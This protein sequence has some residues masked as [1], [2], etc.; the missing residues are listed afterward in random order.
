MRRLLVAALVALPLRAAA[1]AP[2][3]F[4]YLY[5]EANE[6]S[7]SGGHVAARFA[8][9][10][11]HFQNVGG[12]RIRLFRTPFEQFDHQYRVAGNRPIHVQRV[13]LGA[14][15]FERQRD[16]FEEYY[17]RQQVDF[18]ALQALQRDRDLLQSFA[19]GSAHIPRLPGSAY[20]FADGS[21]PGR[22]DAGDA[23]P[24]SAAITA[25]A[26]QLR[27]RYGGE[28]LDHRAAELRAA[29]A[30]LRPAAAAPSHS[31][32]ALQPAPSSVFADRYRDLLSGLLAVE[33]LRGGLPLRATALENAD[34]EG[35][36]LAAGELAALRRA[37]QQLANDL[38][39]LFASRRPDWG[40]PMLIGMARLDAIATSLRSRHLVVLDVFR[41]DAPLV[42][43][44]QI[45][46]HRARLTAL[47]EERRD[48][49]QAARAVFF[50]D[51]RYDESRLS[52]LELAANLLSELRAATR[53]A[54]DL[55]AHVNSLLPEKSARE[56]TLPLPE[57]DA[58]TLRPA[59]AA[60]RDR[61]A[62]YAAALTGRYP[63]HVVTRNCVTELF[64]LLLAAAP[65][66]TRDRS[67]AA[68]PFIPFLSTARLRAL[69]GP[70]AEQRL[71]SYRESALARMYA[72]E[73]DALVYLRESNVLT[74]SLYERDSRDSP[75]LFFT[76][77]AVLPRPVFGVV[78]LATGL[79]TT[80]A[81]LATLPFDGGATV[82]AGA[83]G[84]L[85]S[86]PELSF[87]NIRKG[88]FNFVP[89]RWL[90][91]GEIPSLFSP[92]QEDEREPAAMPS[93]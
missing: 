47:L 1:A 74:S 24:R 6:G 44:D 88:T 70:A 33:V 78:N 71:P 72:A 27:R 62:A 28:V 4:E 93:R 59:L 75:F 30:A 19:G 86:L 61:E 35:T 22:A 15:D 32:A 37:R 41:E 52:R 9:R 14:D 40:S 38:A 42:T 76:D 34:E 7:S 26:R 21:T 12:G 83:R 63:Y 49:Y 55:R 60:S 11:Y 31:G 87:V 29:I 53:T 65:E 54:K 45:R 46:R 58:A 90:G 85:F 77:D 18:E 68:L 25:L 8:D 23:P 57:I 69:Y 17:R 51:D 89:R 39:L 16:T 79:A 80:V 5:I 36:P 3:T 81:G 56:L 73:N 92:R 48:D 84:V 64:R 43:A 50:T 10:C 2:G 13:T 66:A 20:F 67:G 91:G 82:R